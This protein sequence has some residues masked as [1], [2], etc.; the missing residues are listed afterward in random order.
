MEIGEQANE[1]LTEQSF[2]DSP[3]RE[4][5]Q[6]EITAGGGIEGGAPGGGIEGGKMEEE[7]AT[8]NQ[9]EIEDALIPSEKKKE[10]MSFGKRFELGLSWFKR[11]F[12][13]TTLNEWARHTVLASCIILLPCGAACAGA[14]EE[15]LA[16]PVGVYCMV[17]SIFIFPIFWPVIFENEM[18][19]KPI[20]M[21]Q[22]YGAMG[23]IFMLLSIFPY[24]M[25]PTHLGAVVMTFAAI[26]YLL[27][28]IKDEKPKDINQI[29]RIAQGG[30]R[31][32][33]KKD[34]KKN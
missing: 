9:G 10:K 18:L 2:E 11:A 17:I 30:K 25:F 1:D 5:F 26:I 27:S 20:L 34:Q 6:E 8:L 12:E 28:F 14:Y 23:V 7:E 3:K 16:I 22:H 19:R 29:I 21:T 33:K 13:S 15:T 4:S 24:F 32:K 31:Q